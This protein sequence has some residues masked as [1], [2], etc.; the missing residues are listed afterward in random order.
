MQVKDIMTKNIHFIKSDTS[1]MEAAREMRDKDIGSIPIEEN[2]KLVGM[3]TDRDAVIMAVAEGKDPK[4]TS[5]KEVMS[6]KVLYCYEDDSCEDCAENMARN[7]VRRLP[8]MNKEKRLVGIVTLGDLAVR[9]E[10]P[11]AHEAHK[12][13]C[14]P[15]AHALV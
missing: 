2:D 10:K 15:K 12:A 11:I 7:K 13:I 3:L 1:L 9:H 6:N 5:V 14:M 8:V 4:N